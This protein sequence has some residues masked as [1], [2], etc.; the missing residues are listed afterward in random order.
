MKIIKTSNFDQQPILVVTETDIKHADVIL[1][2]GL[3]ACFKPRIDRQD[4]WFAPGHGIDCQG[5]YVALPNAFSAGSFGNVRIYLNVLRSELAVSPEQKQLGVASVA[6]ALRN[7]DGAVTVATI[8][9]D[10]IVKVEIYDYDK[11]QFLPY[12]REQAI[13]HL[14]AED[15]GMLPS[16][17]EYQ[18]LL[19]Q[20]ASKL[21]LWPEKVEELVHQ[22]KMA[23]LSE[24]TMLAK[25]MNNSD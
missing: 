9:P 22:Y 13:G 6:E 18:A 20:H 10:R 25:E 16:V 5:T 8:P 21:H 2:Q 7:E 3:R 17:E 1:T 23:P 15:T 12:S 19:Q 24:K 14:G 11:K 4:Q